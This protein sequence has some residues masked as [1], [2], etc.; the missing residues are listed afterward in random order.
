MNSGPVIIVD[1][2]ADDKE[3]LNEAWKELEYP[4]P[5][6]FFNNGKQ[7]IDYLKSEKQIPF[8]ILCDVNIPGMDG[9]EL[10]KK[11]LEDMSMNYKSIPFV[12]WSSQVSQSQIEK[13]YDLGVNGFFVKDIKFKELKQS[14]RVIV[15][16]WSKSKVPQ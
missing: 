6:L 12:F 2:D 7:V 5:L 3:F 14:L 9:F 13:A 1:A 11:I 16:Y 8:L 10:K 15:N 4:N